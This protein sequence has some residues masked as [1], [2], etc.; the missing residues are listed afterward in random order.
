ME[1]IGVET[2][3]AYDDDIV[4]LGNIREEVAYSLSKLIKAT[5][6]ES[7][8]INEVKTKFMYYIEEM[9]TSQT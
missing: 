1:V 4:L 5:K 3:L 6:N 9:Q 2:V 8:Y 7:L